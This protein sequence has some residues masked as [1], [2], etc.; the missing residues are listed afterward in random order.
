M[1]ESKAGSFEKHGS[2]MTLLGDTRGYDTY[3]L[4]IFA[5]SGFCAMAYEVIWAKLLGLIVGPTTYS[6]TIV[7]VTFISGLALGSIFFG[8]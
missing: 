4:V 6:F 8:W 7:L 5:V 1:A 2:G 3:A